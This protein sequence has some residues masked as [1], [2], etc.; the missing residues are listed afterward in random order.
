MAPRCAAGFLS[1]WRLYAFFAHGPYMPSVKDKE[2]ADEQRTAAA[3]G[4]QPAGS[5]EVR[6]GPRHASK[7]GPAASSTGRSQQAGAGTRSQHEATPAG[8]GAAAAASSTTAA[9]AAAAAGCEVTKE[10]ATLPQQ[11]DSTKHEASPGLANGDIETGTAAAGMQPMQP[12]A[13]ALLADADPG[14]QAVTTSR[15]TS[16]AAVQPVTEAAE[17]AVTVKL[18]GTPLSASSGAASR[19]APTKGGSASG[20]SKRAAAPD[21]PGKSGRKRLSKQ[22]KAAAK[23][24]KRAR[25]HR[26]KRIWD[27]EQP[28]TAHDLIE[29]PFDPP[30]F[31]EYAMEMGYG[32]FQVVQYLVSILTAVTVIY[33]ELQNIN[34]GV[35]LGWA[36]CLMSSASTHGMCVRIACY[37][38]HA[39]CAGWHSGAVIVA[40][41]GACSACLH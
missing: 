13:Q 33:G 24:K 1:P 16:P 10:G 12:G 40:L 14:Q 31:Y 39:G 18:L 7:A 6:P 34:V 2:S 5:S 4:Q 17:C 15:A 23:E 36:R 29:L 32:L 19:P 9:A 3:A 41:R 22:E 35:G 25:G 38:R 28:I 27:Q 26:F 30:A 11:H 8:Q 20:K 37:P 21:A